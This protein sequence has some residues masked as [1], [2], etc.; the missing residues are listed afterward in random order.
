MASSLLKSNEFY[1]TLESILNIHDGNEEWKDDLICYIND[2]SSSNDDKFFYDMLQFTR[3]VKEG[4]DSV[5]YTDPD[6]IIYLNAPGSV[7]GK[8]MPFW[9]FIYDHEC[10]HQLWDTFAV[11]DAIKADKSVEYNH[12]VLNL[13]SDCVINDYLS[14]IRRK[15][16]PPN[17]INAEYIKQNFGIDYDRKKDTQY[18]LYKKMMKVVDKLMKDPLVKKMMQDMKNG[19]GQ[20]GGGGAGQSGQS[21]GQGGGSGQGQSGQGQSGPGGG[22]SDSEIDKMTGQEAADYAKQCAD[23]AQNSAD[24]ASQNAPGSSSA[25][26]AQK[27]ADQAADAAGDAQSAADSGNDK[28]ARQKAKEA[29]DA[30]NKAAGN[31]SNGQKGQGGSGQGSQGQNGQGNGAGSGQGNRSRSTKDIA[32]LADS[33]LKKYRNKITGSLGEFISKCKSSERRE[34]TTVQMKNP[35]G[36]I[37]WN[38]KLETEITAFV[39]E[40]VFNKK[41]E[42]E[43]TYQRVKRGSG[44]IKFGEPIQAGRRIKRDGMV[45]DFAFYIDA[46][47][48]MDS[49]AGSSG[50]NRCQKACDVAYSICSDM[51]RQY[52]RDPVVEEVKSDFYAFDD[53]AYSIKFKEY[54]RPNGGTLE[55]SDLFRFIEK[56]SKNYLVN[57]IITDGGFSGINESEV[58][59]F[60]GSIPGLFIVI[61]NEPNSECKSIEKKGKGKF[62][63]IEADPEFTIK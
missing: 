56:K 11:G 35:Y 6:H 40:N 13:A 3:F 5:A 57:I 46:S 62:V 36:S 59:K 52:D 26:D 28:M 8:N 47:G 37:S 58:L 7:Y 34:D 2:S 51:E 23:A 29:R 33:I 41:R 32:K 61:C 43:S 1:E 44:F 9:E 21:Q 60:V 50:K 63:F 10:L 4:A 14:V 19:G 42:W 24:Q 49:T 39:K 38:K 30:A 31:K 55:M 48:S 27:A 12:F 16:E 54:P 20:Q 17:L 45:V 53:N 22:K 15:K 18:T 25:R